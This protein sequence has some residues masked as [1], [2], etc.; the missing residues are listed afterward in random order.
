MDDLIEHIK[1][2]SDRNC[3]H[4][5]KPYLEYMEHH[6]MYAGCTGLHTMNDEYPKKELIPWCQTL[7][8]LFYARPFRAEV[9]KVQIQQKNP[10]R[11]VNDFG[12]VVQCL[13]ALDDA[14]WRPVALV[15]MRKADKCRED[16]HKVSYHM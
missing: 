3:E 16:N 8:N 7:I 10:K 9:T 13:M 2:I 4:L 5:S 11:L 14:E 12:H 1:S 6:Y 15:A